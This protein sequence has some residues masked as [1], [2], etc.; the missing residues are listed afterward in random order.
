M[1]K[2]ETIQLIQS[3]YPENIEKYLIG[4][5]WQLD[6]AIERKANIWHRSEDEHYDLEVFQ[7]I[8]RS[9]RGYSQR[10]VEILDSLSEFE[11]RSIFDIAKDIV[12]FNSDLVKVRVIHSDVEGGSIPLDD[13]VLL[14]ENAKELLV[15]STLSTFVKKRFFSGGRSRDAQNFIDS[16]RLGQ[17]EVGSFIVSILAPIKYIESKQVD[18]TKSSLTRSVTQNLARSLSAINSA[19]DKFE[20]NGNFM[21]FEEAI[22][23]GVSANLCDALI[24][25]SG[26]SKSRDFEISF[27]L[28]GLDAN[29][30]EIRKSIEFMAKK[31]PVMETASDYYKGSYVI[32]GY[33]L[34]GIVIKMQHEPG[35]DFGIVH[36]SSLVNGQ[37]KN[38]SFKLN[39]EEYWQ[40]VHAHESETPVSCNGDLSV[41]PRSATLLNPNGFKIV[42][43][44]DM[45]DK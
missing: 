41:T 44:Q 38:I 25:I 36:A 23:K 6:K 31:V 22:E 20:S 12:N 33:N 13:G 10:V 17:T 1:N 26:V 16:L 43:M 18:A 29:A 39:L 35:Q 30:K 4:A 19:I 14:I 37:E 28:S 45:F 42:G 7:P 21:V 9:L 15:S 32:N 2:N 34:Y 27:Q 3:I 24:G 40:A 11:S 5:G 8:D